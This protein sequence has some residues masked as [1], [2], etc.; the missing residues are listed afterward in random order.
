MAAQN[1]RHLSLVT[2]SLSMLGYDHGLDEPVIH[3]WNDIGH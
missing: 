2:A 1:G 3:L